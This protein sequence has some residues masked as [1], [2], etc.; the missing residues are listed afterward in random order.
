MELAFPKKKP[1][2]VII[3][4]ASNPGIPWEKGK[5]PQAAQTG[6]FGNL[7]ARRCKQPRGE[8]GHQDR[9]GEK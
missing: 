5:E 1:K 3:F 2:T 4:M 9:L 8:T 6:T 7:R